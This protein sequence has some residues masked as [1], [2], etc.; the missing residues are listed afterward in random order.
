V[1]TDDGL[2][3]V[4]VELGR[5]MRPGVLGQRSIADIAVDVLVFGHAPGHDID[6]DQWMIEWN[7]AVDR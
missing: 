6:I 3:A 7:F 5:G 1:E 4:I 2:H